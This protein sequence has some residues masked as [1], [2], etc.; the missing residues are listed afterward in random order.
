MKNRASFW[1][2]GNL[3][4]FLRKNQRNKLLLYP[5]N[6]AP[7]VKDAIEALGV[8]HPEVGLIYINNE[9]SD[10]NR[11]LQP[12]D[13]VEVF[14][15]Y[16]LADLAA[17]DSLLSILPTTP[18]FVLDVHLGKLAKALRL[19]GFDTL[20]LNNY[21]DA[22]IARLAEEQNRIVL[23][24][25]VGLLKHKIIKWGYWLRSQQPNQQLAEVIV[26]FGLSGY[27]QP[28]TRC[29]ACNGLI[30]EVAKETV[31]AEIPPKTKIYFNQFFRCPSCRR[32]YWK[33]SHYD[34]MSATVAKLFPAES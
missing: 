29:L 18:Q 15:A 5:F 20:Y 31:L 30:I 6:L 23:T 25:D 11:P 9:P 13:L 24:R 33:G 34:N 7:A 12:H 19:F 8:P 22:A 1:F 26:N 4:D 16:P 14:P 17:T 27:Y 21:T 32:V 3:N 2:S 28:L 10:F